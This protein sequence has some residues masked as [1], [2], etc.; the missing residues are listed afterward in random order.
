MAGAVMSIHRKNLYNQNTIK[1]IPRR[2]GAEF[3]EQM[4]TV[5]S[6]TGQP[7]Q[8]ASPACGGQ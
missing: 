4:L 1:K 6:V 2:S 5:T 3:F 8:F 7:L